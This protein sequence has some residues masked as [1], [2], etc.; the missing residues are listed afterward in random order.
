MGDDMDGGADIADMA[1]NDV[2]DD[3]IDD[4]AGDFNQGQNDQQ[5]LIQN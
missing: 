2:D 3:D 1:N 4:F 5:D